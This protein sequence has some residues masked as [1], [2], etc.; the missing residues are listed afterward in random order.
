MVA[1]ARSSASTRIQ[2]ILLTTAHYFEIRAFAEPQRELF[3]GE[4]KDPLPFHWSDVPS[5]SARHPPFA[6][7]TS[8]LAG[9]SHP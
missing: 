7:S 8:R 6:S 2:Q 1:I 9:T 3:D 5:L 4:F